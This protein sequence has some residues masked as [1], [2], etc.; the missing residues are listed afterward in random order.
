M[1]LKWFDKNSGIYR[2][3]QTKDELSDLLKELDMCVYW[4]N[5]EGVYIGCNDVAAKHVNLNPTALIGKNDSDLFDSEIVAE[6]QKNDMKVIE[7]G[8]TLIFEENFVN[9]KSNCNDREYSISSKSP[10]YNKQGQIAGIIGVTINITKIRTLERELQNANSDLLK[11]LD[12]LHATQRQFLEN[13]EHDTRTPLCGIVGAADVLKALTNDEQMLTYIDYI[14]RSGK[15]LN[16]YNEE[17][18]AA[19][20]EGEGYYT[21][22]MRRF[23]LYDLVDRIYNFNYATA[24][25]KQLDYQVVYER[26]ENIPEFFI[27]DKQL[28]SRCLINIIGNAVQ[29]TEA[30]YIHITISPFKIFDHVTWV[31]F[32]IKDSGIGIPE[33]K[34]D[35]IFELFKKV[36]PSNKG[37]QRRSRGVGLT[38]AKNAINELE[39]ELHLKSQL[40]KGSEF[41][42]LLPL[43]V[44][45]DQDSP[46]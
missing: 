30:G 19:L 10:L 17:L 25:M 35:E 29:F 39:G 46:E 42:V 34:Q 32:N 36:D 14:K 11:T 1:K 24:N 43:N 8:E 45:I 44:T 16:A 40:G 41:R 26:K 23:S 27:S 15:E 12:K 7:T 2:M 38:L 3:L 4:K 6:Y 5:P 9:R 13:Q 22:T 31:E 20:Y 18:L 37:G 33:K 28:I 21:H